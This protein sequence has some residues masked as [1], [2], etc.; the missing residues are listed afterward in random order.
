MI[1]SVIAIV[2]FT[3]I[4]CIKYKDEEEPVSLEEETIWELLGTKTGK[5]SMQ[6]D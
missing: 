4:Y 2:G 6:T 1:V 5:S 3:I